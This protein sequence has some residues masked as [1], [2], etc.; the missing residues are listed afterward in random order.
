MLPG[1]PRQGDLDRFGM[2]PGVDDD[3]RPLVPCF[4]KESHRR[5]RCGDRADGAATEGDVR[6]TRVED[7]PDERSQPLVAGT[8]IARK[9]S[10]TGWVVAAGQPD[11]VA[12]VDAR[13]A[14]QCQLEERR[15]ADGG[16]IAAEDRVDPR[17]IVTADE[18]ELDGGH[19]R[20]V[21]A[22]EVLET[23]G[24]AR[25][26]EIVDRPSVRVVGVDDPPVE[27]PTCGEAEDRR[28]ERVVHQRVEAVAAEPVGR[29]VPD[30]SDEVG[31][32]TDG[33]ATTAELAPESRVV[34]LGRDVEPPA[35]RAEPEPVLGGREEVLADRRRLDGELRQGR[36]APPGRV[37]E[38][39]VAARIRP[40][41][42]VRIELPFAGEDVRVEVEPL[43]VRRGEPVLDDVM[44]RPEAAAAVVEHAVEDDPHPPAVSLGEELA[45]GLVPAEE[46]VDRAV[47]VGVVAMVGG[48]GEDRREVEGGDAKLGEVRQS[49]GDTEQVAALEAVDGRRAV[50]RLE[51]ARLGDALA[52]SE[53]VW[54]DLVEDGVTDPVGC[55]DGA[56]HPAGLAGDSARRAG[57]ERA[58]PA[59]EARGRVRPIAELIRD[60]ADPLG[61]RRRE[62]IG[63]VEGERDGGL[64]D[65]GRAGDIRD[66][67]ASRFRVNHP[68][69][70]PLPCRSVGRPRAAARSPDIKPVY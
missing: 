65:A 47:V 7:G 19:R 32:G 69:V 33:P 11:L 44:E 6:V 14:G 5:R 15:E 8:G 16:P 13:R 9:G 22:H 12:V 37:A 38:S 4:A 55:V 1:Q 59:E 43:P 45:E 24:E 70:P 68:P 36:Q 26:I 67:H 29:L 61:G 31:V 41:V 35:V 66:R 20:V 53:P 27:P 34:D 62:A 48:R 52:R 2:A 30:L 17:R 3:G 56:V 58:S 49:L 50:P 60:G 18:V 54:E 42:R 57:R 51:P 63:P 39:T 21:E 10:P 46:R 23:G 40:P 25:S 64:R 28:P